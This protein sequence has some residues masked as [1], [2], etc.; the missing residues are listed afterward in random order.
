MQ[1]QLDPSPRNLHRLQGAATTR[2]KK[3]WAKD[4]NR[5]VFK[6]D[7]CMTSKYMKR[8]LISLIIRKMQIKTMRYHLIL[9]KMDIIQSL[10]ITNTGDGVKKRESFYMLM[11]M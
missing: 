5:H 10:Q 4:L 11:G 6:D 7:V 8:C 1:L 2:K 9:V 3:K